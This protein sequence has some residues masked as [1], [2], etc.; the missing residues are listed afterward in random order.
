M[1]VCVQGMRNPLDGLKV[2]QR[3][4]TGDGHGVPPGGTFQYFLKVVP[5]S[6]TTLGN[7][8]ITS[9]Q[10]SVTEHFKEPIPGAPQQLPV[11]RVLDLNLVSLLQIFSF[12]LL[13]IIFFHR[14]SHLR[15]SIYVVVYGLYICSRAGPVFLL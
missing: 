11:R 6:Y 8:T 3:P 13:A 7:S 5:T 14:E 1:C 10:Y 15:N 2:Q 4:V 9:N 12:F